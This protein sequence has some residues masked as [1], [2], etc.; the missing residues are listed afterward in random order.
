MSR[1]SVVG[2]GYVGLVTGACVAE[3]GNHDTC[4]DAD[5]EKIG[6]LR[7]GTVPSCDPGLEDVVRR[8]VSAG[9]LSVTASYAEGQ[10]NAEFVFIAVN[11]AAGPL[12]RNRSLLRTCSLL[13]DGRSLAGAGDHRDSA[14]AR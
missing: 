11:N 9:R 8:N 5:A 3:L 6:A 1:V 13:I 2:T 4:I 14:A 7:K 12:R 10:K